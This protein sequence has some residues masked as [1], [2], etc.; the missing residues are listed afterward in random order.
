MKIISVACNTLC[1]NAG[2]AFDES[3]GRIQVMPPEQSMFN[4][5]YNWLNAQPKPPYI[6]FFHYIHGIGAAALCVRWGTYLA[7]LMDH[8]KPIDSRAK[9]SSISMISD[10]EIMRI[11]IEVSTN[12]EHLF[13]YL[14]ADEFACL[15]LLERAYA[16]LPM[17]HKRVKRDPRLAKVITASAAIHDTRTDIVQADNLAEQLVN[18]PYRALANFVALWAYRNGEIENAH[19]GLYQGYSLTHRR[20]SSRQERTIM[21]ETAGKLSGIITEPLL[22]QSEY[23][24][25]GQWPDNVAALAAG[26]PYYYPSNWT[27]DSEC[28]QVNL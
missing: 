4:Q 6:G 3:D 7:V 2:R 28:P 20:F 24:G 18:H 22:W 15:E 11:N 1:L 13:Q 23:Q 8:D 25:I 14:H 26:F 21:R 5:I 9:D 27:L 12:L 16:Y 17:P 19:A 10:S